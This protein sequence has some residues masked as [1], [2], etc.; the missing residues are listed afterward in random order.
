MNFW[1]DLKTK[2]VGEDKSGII[3][4]SPMDG[5]TD[6]PFRK[7]VATHGKPDVMYTEFVCVDEIFH[8]KKDVISEFIYDDIQR[9]IVAQVFGISPDLFY[10]AAQL[11]CELGFDGIDI[12]MG[13]PSKNVSQRGA[14]AGLIKNPQ[15]AAEIIEA[16]KKGIADWVENGFSKEFPS[17]VQVKMEAT[18]DALVK[19]G[20][21]LPSP[22][23]QGNARESIPVSVKTRI[24]YYGNEVE[25][26]I[27]FLIKQ[28]VACIAL[29]GRT[30]KQMYTG[31]AD[32]QAIGRAKE[33]ID[34]EAISNPTFVKPLLLGNGDIQSLEQAHE[35]CVKYNIDGVLIGRAFLGRP[36]LLTP[37]LP[38][39][40][41][42]ARQ[43]QP[44]KTL[45]TAQAAGT[46]TTNGDELALEK[47]FAIILEHSKLQE[48]FDSKN[49]FRVRKHL[50]W[51]CKGFR[52]ASELR[53]SL[54]L[55]SNFAEV[56]NI[57]KNFLTKFTDRN[58]L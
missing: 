17:K 52:G 43:P 41:V 26:W 57:L 47:I 10:I 33:L 21:K 2:K 20:V 36:W 54:V 25:T 37:G 46:E 14:G 45:Q 38:K 11:V 31:K 32:W 29:H 28:D 19:M 44:E 42:T 50:A 16:T 40:A 53:S 58:N 34:L 48:D 35:Y 23:E 13:C 4:L 15:L 1:Q 12:N 3:A 8:S 27:G 18:K 22:A 39:Q 7:V 56:E 30:Y 9:P 51:Y 49:F 5:L 6:Y 24:G 55:S